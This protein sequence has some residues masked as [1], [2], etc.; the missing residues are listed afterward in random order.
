[1]RG[2]PGLGQREDEGHARLVD[3]VPLGDRAAALG[4][5]V[6]QPAGPGVAGAARDCGGEALDVVVA[7]EGRH[8]AV[9]VGRLARCHSVV[10]VAEA[11]A[12]AREGRADGVVEREVEL[13]RELVVADVVHDEAT[14]GGEGLADQVELGPAAGLVLV[15]Q[16][17]AQGAHDDV[18]HVLG[19][20]DAHGVDVVVADQG[21][22]VG[23]HAL[24]ELVLLVAEVGQVA[25]E[26]ALDGLLLPAAAR[27]ATDAALAE[28]LRVLVDVVVVLVHVVEHEVKQDADTALVGL[29]DELSELLLA[30]ALGRAPAL[31]DADGLGGP[32]AVVARVPVGAVGAEVA[33]FGVFVDRAEPDG[34]HAELV[35]VALLQ[36]IDDALEVAALVVGGGGHIGDGGEGLA[37]VVAVAE[38]VGEDEVEQGIFPLE[39]LVL[40]P[41]G[42]EQLVLGGDARSVGG[43]HAQAVL[44]GGQA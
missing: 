11:A 1:M 42:H 26:P 17:L 36:S 23:E 34:G 41:E 38:A 28:P 16:A 13:A 10:E 40:D 6:V 21:H 29:L 7:Q 44:A 43:G 19:G 18:V 25:R 2:T 9:S 5:G 22:G 31:L 8:Q 15:L 35:E 33:P 30:A 14:V 24:G 39:G 4:H 37:A 20:V 27:S 3:E 32:V 12:A